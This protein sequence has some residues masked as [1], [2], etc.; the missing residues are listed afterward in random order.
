M[1]WWITNGSA[2]ATLCLLA[3]CVTPVPSD[4][5]KNVPSNAAPAPPQASKA[6]ERGLAF[7]VTD[8][9]KWRKERA[10]ATCHHGT[11]TVWALSEAKSQGF[12]A[13]AE[14]LAET[15]TWTKERLK[16]ID[17]PRDTRPGWSMVSTPAVYL[18]VMAQTVPQQDAVSADELKQIAGHLL[19]HQETDGAWAWS[20]APAQNRPPPV[21]ESDEVVTLM[22]YLALGPHVP[23]D[24]TEKSAVRDSREKAAA[25]LE[26]G[27]SSQ[28][29]QAAALRLLRDVRAGKPPTE[30]QAG[31]DGILGWQ[32]Q[33]GGWGQEPGLPSDAYA[34]GQALYFLRL[35]GMKNDHGKI[36]RAQAF[37]VATQKEDGSWPMTSRAHPGAKPFTNPVPNT[38]F[39]SAWA[40]MGLLRTLPKETVPTR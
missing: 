10:C 12:A 21:F 23:A 3:V 7:L 38:Y 32:N 24:A 40:T 18:A 26:K 17:K 19:R 37:L 25:W 30:L 5:P 29:T 6:V 8:A 39:G 28:S 1:H 27:K 35:A 34:T 14:S 4:D 20:S 22:A 2:L 16:D 15:V 11:M 33:D 13:N 31:I 36:R 9:A